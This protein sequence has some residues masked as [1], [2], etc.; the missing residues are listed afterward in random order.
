[1]LPLNPKSSDD[2]QTP[3]YA[4]TPLLPFLP[5]DKVIWECACGG[6]N[7]V[8]A[9][10]SDGYK[11]RGTDMKAG[12][13]F[14]SF[15]PKPESLKGLIGGRK[16]PLGDVIVTNPPYS[17]KDDFLIT[18][19]NLGL[20]FAFLMP[21]TALEGQDRQWYYRRYGLELIVLSER[22]H[23]ETPSGKG[24]HCWFPVAWFCWKLT[25]RPLTFAAPQWGSRRSPS[26][27]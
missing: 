21:L 15:N 13:D 5:K 2:F 19:Y 23:F 22:L 20:P 3:A 8:K 26:P 11:V 7:L 4:L 10:R 1:M 24:S 27:K 17:L 6:R 14:R 12:T 16:K 18:A 9:L 25:G